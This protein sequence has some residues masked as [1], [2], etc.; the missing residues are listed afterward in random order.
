MNT[1]QHAWR[2]G[3]RCRLTTALNRL[4]GT[5]P[6]AATVLMTI[7]SGMLN[8]QNPNNGAANER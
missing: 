1:P 5:Y 7:I 6:P 2:L 8:R 3:C 4:M